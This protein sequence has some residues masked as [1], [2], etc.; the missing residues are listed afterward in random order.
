M[1]NFVLFSLI[2]SKIKWGR[3]VPCSDFRWEK[4]AMDEDDYELIFT[5]FK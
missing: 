5:S 4:Y 2:L 1:N 3:L